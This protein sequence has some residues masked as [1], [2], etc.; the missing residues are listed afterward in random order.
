M[1]TTGTTIFLALLI[2]LG[3]LGVD[4]WALVA[5]GSVARPESLQTGFSRWALVMRNSVIAQVGESASGV[6]VGLAYPLILVSLIQLIA[7]LLC[8]GRRYLAWRVLR[9]CCVGK[10]ALYLIY[11]G[12]LLVAAANAAQGQGNTML[13]LGLETLIIIF[14]G[15][16][17]WWFTR[18]QT[19]AEFAPLPIPLEAAETS[20]PT[21]PKAG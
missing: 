4:F 15:V 5:L 12:V 13:G 3:A 14:Y 19:A 18:D 17:Y 6:V 11:I 8:F 10:M 21:E 7:A 2:F 9:A 16:A 20:T 1:R